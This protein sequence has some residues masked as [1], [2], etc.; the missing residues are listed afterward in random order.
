MD[1]RVYVYRDLYENCSSSDAGSL[2]A[3]MSTQQACG[4]QNT[5]LALSNRVAPFLIRC[6][7]LSDAAARF[8]IRPLD[9]SQVIIRSRAN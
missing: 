5:V 7:G 9:P 3:T 8:F 4:L 6:L 1:L 2:C